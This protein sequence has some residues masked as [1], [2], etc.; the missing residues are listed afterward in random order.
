[1]AVTPCNGFE[2]RCCQVSSNGIGTLID[3][4]QAAFDRQPID[5]PTTSV[6]GC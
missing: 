5:K 2:R 6:M 3:E 4:V 1:M